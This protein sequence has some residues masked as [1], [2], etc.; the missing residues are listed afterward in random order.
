[1]LSSTR[2]RRR[3]AVALIVFAALAFAPAAA[4]AYPHGPVRGAADFPQGP[5]RPALVMSV[6]AQLAAHNQ[7]FQPAGHAA[8]LQDQRESR[9]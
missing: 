9:S 3:H 4:N 8:V 2:Y 1:M 5:I 6:S 7:T